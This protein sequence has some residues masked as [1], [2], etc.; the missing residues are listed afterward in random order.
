MGEAWG[1]IAR[2]IA[3][4]TPSESRGEVA[5]RSRKSNRW[6]NQPP[7]TKQKAFAEAQCY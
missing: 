1:E 4:R 3:K 5:K 7:T 6:A 2:R